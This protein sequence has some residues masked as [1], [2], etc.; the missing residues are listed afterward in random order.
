MKLPGMRWEMPSGQAV[1]SLRAKLKSGLWKRDVVEA[2][3]RHFD[4]K[5]ARLFS[6]QAQSDIPGEIETSKKVTF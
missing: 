5:P 4:V 2:S 1:L 3:Y 6:L